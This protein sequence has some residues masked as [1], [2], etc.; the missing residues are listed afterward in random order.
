[1]R[2]ARPFRAHAPGKR[3]ERTRETAHGLGGRGVPGLAL[4]R[5][6]RPFPLRSLLRFLARYAGPNAPQYALGGLMLGATNW[7]VVRIPALI[8]DALNVLAEQGPQGLRDARGLAVELLI[9]AVVVVIVRTLSRVLFFNPGRDAEFKVKVDLFEHMLLLQRPFYMRR[10]VGDLVSVA[11]NDT[12]S[13][14]LLLGFAGLQLCNMLVAVPLHLWQMLRTDLVLTAWCLVPVSIGGIYMRWT[15]KR[16]F[17]LVRTSMAELGRLSDR[18]LETYAASGTLRAHAAEDGAMARF[19]QRNREYLGLQM[20]IASMRAFAMPVLGFTG[21][22]GASVVLWIGGTRVV[23]GELQIGSLVTFNALLLTLV[24]TLTGFAWVLAA[25]SRGFVAQGRIAD[26]LQTEDGLPP[27]S[28]EAVPN[29]PP[30]IRLDDLS[31]TYPDG[32]APALEGISAT[33]RPGGT[34]GIFGKT[35]SGKTTLVNVI[36]RV[37]APPMGSVFFD[38]ADAAFLPLGQLRQAMAV[39]PQDPFLF[40]TTVRDNVRLL[41]ERTGHDEAEG[42]EGVDTGPDAELDR[43][44]EAASLAPDLGQLPQGLDT[45]VGER[46]VMLSGGQRQRLALARAFYRRAPILLLDDVLS[47]VDQTTESRLVAAIR[48]VGEKTDP[49][50][51]II[52]SHRTS[53]LEHADEILVLEG[54]RVAE[55]GT[56]AELLAAGGEYAETHAHQRSDHD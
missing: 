15:V 52:V 10:K 35:G 34:L 16:F 32:D 1:M 14:R 28:E 40:S 17:G 3:P 22:V 30:A 29:Q 43:V 38:G 31:F 53:V 51:T 55:R 46:G 23:E 42:G 39:V 9:W 56:H 47:A 19:E 8:G 27:P 2:G 49:P 21:L 24:A 54:G 37:Q 41:G 11:S 50:T 13:V 44:L 48:G 25:I 12:N 36:S 5:F 7:V 33:V 20:R 6:R 26:I 18:I 4:S 45:V